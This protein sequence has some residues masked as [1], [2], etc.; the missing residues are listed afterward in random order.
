MSGHILLHVDDIGEDGV[1]ESEDVVQ[2]LRE[3]RLGRWKRI[4]DGDT[5]YRVHT[6]L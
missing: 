4:Y 3:F 2:R 1:E 6:I 5:D